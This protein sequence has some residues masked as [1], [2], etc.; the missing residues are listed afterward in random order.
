MRGD[1]GVVCQ[2]RAGPS[3][4]PPRAGHDMRQAGQSVGQGLA[5]TRRRHGDEVPGTRAGTGNRGRGLIPLAVCRWTENPGIPRNDKHRSRTAALVNIHI[6]LHIHTYIHYMHTLHTYTQRAIQSTKC[7][8]PS[9]EHCRPR[10]ALERGRLRKRL[11]EERVDEAAKIHLMEVQNGPGA[12]VARTG[13]GGQEGNARI[14]AAYERT[15]G[16]DNSPCCQPFV[17]FFKLHV[18]LLKKE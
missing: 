16:T 8:T 15:V 4:W 7:H 2:G 11:H 5:A 17:S 14:P 18:S 12:E 13:G 6:Y 9:G 10:H 1:A 3:R